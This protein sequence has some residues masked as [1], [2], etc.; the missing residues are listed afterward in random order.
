MATKAHVIDHIR[1]YNP[2]ARVQWLLAFDLGSLQ[3][4]LDH[5][6]VLIEPRGSTWLRTGETHAINTRVALH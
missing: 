6:Q 4:Y 3:H 5:L 1:K 2:T